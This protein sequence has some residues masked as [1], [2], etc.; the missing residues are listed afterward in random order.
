MTF[1]TPV[2]RDTLSVMAFVVARSDSSL[3]S[4]NGHSFE[5]I[6][7][8]VLCNGLDAPVTNAALAI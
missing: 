7:D 8:I 5:T 2:T 4:C 1:T 3:P 6:T